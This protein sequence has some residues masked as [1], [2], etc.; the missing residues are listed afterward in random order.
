MVYYNPDHS[1]QST[2]N[3]E[4][5]PEF[6][7]LDIVAMTIAVFQIIIPPLL[8]FFGVVFGLYLLL[9]LIW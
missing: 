8:M 9:R 6:S 1:Q 3:G 4:K 5:P 7:F 2:E